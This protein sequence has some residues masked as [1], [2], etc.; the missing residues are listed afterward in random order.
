MI[1][2]FLSPFF[3]TPFWEITP[4]HV[5]QYVTFRAVVAFITSLLFTFLTGPLFIRLSQL[6]NYRENIS[7]YLS[8]IGHQQKNGTPSMGGLIFLS[9][10]LFSA[11]LWI[12]LSNVYVLILFFSAI[13]LGSIGFIDDYL[14][15]VKKYK[16]GL[17]ARY[18]L[19]GQLILGLAIAIYLFVYHNGSAEL[20]SLNIPFFRISFTAIYP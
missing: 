17:I 4:F 14:K 18:K 9:G 20:T 11:F 15:N 8:E 7:S 19:T 3:E 16:P 1:Y 6:N 5:V 13:W 12:D 2:K 10:T